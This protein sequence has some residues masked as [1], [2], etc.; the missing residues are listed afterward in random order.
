MGGL[1][2][3]GTSRVLQPGADAQ[4]AGAGPDQHAGLGQYL[5]YLYPYSIPYYRRKGWEVV[6]D[7]ISYVI[8]DFKPLRPARC[9]AV[10]RVKTDSEALQPDLRL[11]CPAYPRSG[12]PGRA[13]LE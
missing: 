13:G 11:L 2:G 9:P 7:K 3:V 6:S 5:S 1:T 4:A 10:R 12:A 8:Q